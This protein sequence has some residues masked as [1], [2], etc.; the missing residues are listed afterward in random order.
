VKVAL[1]FS[2]FAGRD[3]S[4]MPS[5]ELG[6]WYFASSDPKQNG[7]VI[8]SSGLVQLPPLDTRESKLPREDEDESEKPPD[9]VGRLE[10]SLWFASRS[11]H[12][13]GRSKQS[14][15]LTCATGVLGGDNKRPKL[16]GGER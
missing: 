5:G 4:C 13:C 16:A 12:C 1:S 15:V 10:V 14:T 11:D 8:S 9:E 6:S 7:S 3:C 2:F